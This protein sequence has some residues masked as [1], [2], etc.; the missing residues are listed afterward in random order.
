[1]KILAGQFS[2]WQEA[3]D[4]FRKNVEKDLKEIRQCKQEVQQMKEELVSKLDNGLYIRNGQRIVMSAPEII[5]GNV[6]R[7]GILY[8]ND[9]T[10]TVRG[11]ELRLEGTGTDGNSTGSITSRAA[12]IRQIA[13]DPGIDGV[14]NVVRET[15]EIISQAKTLV[16]RGEESD[17]TF[18]EPE[19][20]SGAGGVHISTDSIISL[21]A[22]LQSKTLKETLTKRENNL[23]KIV[24]NLK[25]E[26]DKARNNISRH[27]SQLNDLSGKETLGMDETLTRTNLL[28]IKDNHEEFERKAEIL[29]REMTDYFNTLSKLSEYNRQLTDTKAQK[30][31]VSKNE[32]T[33]KDKTTGTYITVNS[34]NI[35]L[36]SSDGE[37][38]IRTNGGAGVK[39]AGR[40]IHLTTYDTDGSLIKDGNVRLGAENINISTYSPKISDKS[41]EYP[42]EG[43]VSIIS[44][45][46]DIQAVDYEIKDNQTK[47]KSLT[48]EGRFRVRAE[49]IAF[50]STDT[51]GKATGTITAN[52]K[53]V[54]LKAVDI[55]NEKQTDKSVAE[56][57]TLLM[58]GEKIYAGSKDKKNKSKAIQMASDKI[59][60]FGDTTVELQQDAK[61]ILQLDGG[62]A[63]LSGS[64][65][66]LYGETTSEGKTTFKSDISAGTVN[67]KNLKVET[68]FKTPYTTE[69]IS[70][71][72]APSTA[73]LGAKLKE[74]EIKSDK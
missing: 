10:V 24:E 61:A 9:S 22:T 62:N 46:I 34:E 55:D 14:E 53:Q 41:S 32:S 36:I 70:V 42:A 57:G 68:S 43:K 8:N 12:S 69:G 11:N 54:E 27:I 26:A 23:K 19:T 25:K 39:V 13:V 71:P 59:G 18:Q 38:N 1:M 28:E 5:I 35:N 47:E 51:E 72:G 33:F 44:K 7:N 73:K 4:N 48:K 52:A 30:E 16:L 37:G 63:A 74:E 49:K 3:L 50:A 40:Q 21:N 64:K 15:S 29:Y 65:T 45:D 60:I 56:G 31:T 2:D 66:T 17:G 67:M 58:V 20:G 6:D